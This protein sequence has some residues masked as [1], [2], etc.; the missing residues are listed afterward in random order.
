[1]TPGFDGLFANK[2][3]LL[4]P[5]SQIGPYLTPLVNMWLMWML[6]I[7][8]TAL[9]WAIKK[10]EAR[11]VVLAF[12]GSIAAGFVMPPIIGADNYVYAS[13]SLSHMVFWTP[14]VIAII[15]RRRSVNW[16]SLYGFWL[17]LALAT[18]LV[19]LLFDWRDG[20]VYLSFLL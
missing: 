13:L 17:G 3:L 2:A 11:Y 20:L 18:M 10:V 16:K 1:M 15:M 7:G 5:A 14:A 6:A 9:L 4:T 19:S 8:V 12:V